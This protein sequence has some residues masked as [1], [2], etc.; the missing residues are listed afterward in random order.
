MIANASSR[1]R[2]MAS[3]KTICAAAGNPAKEMGV[4]AAISAKGPVVESAE[5][6]NTIAVSNCTPVMDT[7]TITDAM[8]I[9]NSMKNTHAI[10]APCL[11]ICRAD[12][13]APPTEDG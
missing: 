9:V 11:R 4:S 2:A 8:D 3:A 1:P 7:S 12:A 6:D 10:C 13:P 5:T